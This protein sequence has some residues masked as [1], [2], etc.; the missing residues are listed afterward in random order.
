MGYLGYW[1]KISYTGIRK[2]I[3]NKK[4]RMLVIKKRLVYTQDF[5][6]SKNVKKRMGG[7]VMQRRYL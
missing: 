3:L 7:K 5:H 6:S 2:F 1:D 4:L